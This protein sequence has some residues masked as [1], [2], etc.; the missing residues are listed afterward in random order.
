MLRL[1]R[2]CCLLEA[3]RPRHQPLGLVKNERLGLCRVLVYSIHPA[4]GRSRSSEA[5]AQ[6]SRSYSH[7]PPLDRSRD[8]RAGCTTEHRQRPPLPYGPQSRS[9]QLSPRAYSWGFTPA[10]PA[11]PLPLQKI[12]RSTGFGLLLR[13]SD[14]LDATEAFLLVSPEGL[15]VVSVE[16]VGQCSQRTLPLLQIDHLPRN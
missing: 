16:P 7:F 11:L 2:E 9:H 15:H 14:L 6:A 1:V 8:A 5:Q 10:A 13:V 12:S 3:T 4:P